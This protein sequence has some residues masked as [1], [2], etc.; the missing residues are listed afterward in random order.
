MSGYPWV[1]RLPLLKYLFSQDNRQRTENEIVFAITP[2]IIR[3]LDV[4]EQN[5]RTIEVGNGNSTELRRKVPAPVSATP[6]QPAD[7]AKPRQSAPAAPGSS[8]P[9]ASPQSRSGAQ[10]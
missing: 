3:A 6:A 7:P 10:R 4:T 2:H 1:S 9:P 8:V 5:M